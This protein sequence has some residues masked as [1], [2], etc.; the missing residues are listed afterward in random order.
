MV[1]NEWEPVIDPNPGSGTKSTATGE[2]PCGGVVGVAAAWF[3]AG[4]FIGLLGL[5]LWIP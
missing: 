2:Y 4:L 3:V 5:I 1:Q